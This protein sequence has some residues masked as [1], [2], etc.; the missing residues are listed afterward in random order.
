MKH[1]QKIVEIADSPITI[2]KSSNDSIELIEGS[3]S[4]CILHFSH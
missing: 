3:S 1:V 2:F 4:A